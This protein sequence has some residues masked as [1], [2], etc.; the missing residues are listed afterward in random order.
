MD[1]LINFLIS[2]LD[3]A[4]TLVIISIGLAVVF[5]MMRVINFAH[6]EFL[7]LG[8]FVTVSSVRTGVPF[9]LAIPVSGVAVGAFGL[10]VERLVIQR[11]YGRLA[12]TM[13]AT[14]GL[15]LIMVKCAELIWGTST[16]GIETP[17]GSF[18]IGD[19]SFSV[20][21][22]VTIGAAL[23]L[24]AGMLWVFTRTRF[25][26]QARAATQLPGM[27]AA[28]GVNARRLSMLTFALGSA[29]AG[30]AGA[31][32]APVTAVT[33]NMGQA[34]IAQA[35]TTV[36]VG[37]PAVVTGTASAGGL[38][39]TTQTTISEL[40]TAVLGVAALLVTAIVVLR[41]LPTGLS[42]RSK[43]ML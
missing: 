24:L 6:G 12:A 29:L 32:L 41:F 11:L 25:G 1:A 27:A 42:G 34:Y 30:V 43:A 15:S 23:V 17:L 28:L 8:A 22:L 16:Q 18:R 33:P 40:T 9:W 21:T 13:L 14:F 2:L 36:V 35:F 5:G 38:L 3:S 39:G 4:A 19:Y 26:I 10:V 7:M 37:G 31:L 20:Y